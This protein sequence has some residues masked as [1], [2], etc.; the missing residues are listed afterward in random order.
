MISKAKLQFFQEVENYLRRC[1]SVQ[2]N[3]P[4]GRPSLRSTEGLGDNGDPIL[5]SYRDDYQ[6]VFGKFMYLGPRPSED[7]GGVCIMF[8][9]PDEEDRELMKIRGY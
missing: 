4:E 2:K 7:G 8:W 6:K 3:P 9:N 5:E 1:W